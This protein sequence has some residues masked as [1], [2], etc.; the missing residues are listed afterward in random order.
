MAD[1][2]GASADH[3]GVGFAPGLSF[4]VF[5][6]RDIN[7]NLVFQPEVV[8]SIRRVSL[9]YDYSLVV[10][11]V[12]FEETAT[13]MYAEF[14]CLLKLPFPAYPEP[15]HSIF[16]GPVWSL[17]MSGKRNGEFQSKFGTVGG[18]SYS[19]SIGN[20]AHFD[21]GLVVGW[22]YRFRG[23]SRLFLMDARYVLGLR[24][25]FRDVDRP[26]LIPENEY[27]FIH[28]GSGEAEEMR[29][30]TFEVSFGICSF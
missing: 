28:A 17:A 19:G 13:L 14:P 2:R 18:G 6:S 11:V 30:G 20:V 3:R 8:F 7:S 5:Y 15:Q 10:D 24:G 9:K 4:G 1:W 25:V 16:F 21:I 29:S 23:G 12:R 22:E 27:P 26:D